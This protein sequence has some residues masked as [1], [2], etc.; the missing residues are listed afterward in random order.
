VGESNLKLANESTT[1]QQQASM[2][3][4]LTQIPMPPGWQQART[5]RGEI[6]FINHNTRTTS[7]D[8]PR[9][10]LVPAYL[11]RLNSSSSA[12][13]KTA[14]AGIKTHSNELIS[15]NNNNIAQQP[16][17]ITPPIVNNIEQIKSTLIE[18]LNK[19]TELEKSLEEVS[20]Q[21]IIHFET[22]SRFQDFIDSSLESR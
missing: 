11:A 2:E 5:N 1:N 9:L 3:M 10:P 18:S 15:N 17:S 21:V 13:V 14:L 8:D 22:L 6:Y 19:K 16:Q 12:D 7:W 4:I 20:K